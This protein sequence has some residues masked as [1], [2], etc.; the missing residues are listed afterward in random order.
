MSTLR[1]RLANVETR[2]LPKPPMERRGSYET[3]YT[4]GWPGCLDYPESNAQR[5]TETEHGPNC[6][7]MTT[8]V[9]SGLRRIIVLRGAGAGPW[10]RI[11]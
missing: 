1:R 5:C 2:L 7:V 3:H 9:F 10:M 6:A 11:E 8:P 4:D